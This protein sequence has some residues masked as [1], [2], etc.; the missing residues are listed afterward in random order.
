MISSAHVAL[1]CRR[2]VH[3]P[4]TAEVLARA[5]PRISVIVPVLDEQDRIGQRLEELERMPGIDEVIVVDG[6]SRD[7]TPDIVAAHHGAKLLR[8]SVVGRC[9]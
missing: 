1:S 9:R 8:T 4:H 2:R 6:G 7:G 3:A 5:A